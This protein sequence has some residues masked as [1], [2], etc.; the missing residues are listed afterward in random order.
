MDTEPFGNG[1][2][3]AT[4]VNII[5]LMRPNAVNLCV[6]VIGH[7]RYCTIVFLYV[8][9]SSIGNSFPVKVVE[10]DFLTYKVKSSDESKIV[11]KKNAKKM[12]IHFQ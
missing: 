1:F 10:G 4:N 3:R 6:V 12:L 11:L 2:N 5:G 9:I 8:Y 7:R